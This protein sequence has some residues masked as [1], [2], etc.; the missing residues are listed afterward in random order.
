MGLTCHDTGP[1]NAYYQV[2][3]RVKGDLS[4]SSAPVTLTITATGVPT[5]VTDTAT[6][7]FARGSNVAYVG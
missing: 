4:F 7:T 3:L 5:A 2:G 1:G 6:V